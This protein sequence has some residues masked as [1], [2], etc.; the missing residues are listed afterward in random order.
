M[1]RSVIECHNIIAT[2]CPNLVSLSFQGDYS[3][4]VGEEEEVET[5][6]LAP[7]QEYPAFHTKVGSCT[8]L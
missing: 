2:E 6:L 3:Y 1:F 5:V 4:T 8:F 7:S